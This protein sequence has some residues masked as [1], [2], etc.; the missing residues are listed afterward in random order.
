[1]GMSDWSFLSGVLGT[2]DVTRDPVSDPPA[3]PGGGSFVYGFD[4]KVDTIGAVALKVDA[5]NNPDH[6][7]SAKGASV[8]GAIMRGVS[9]EKTNFSPFLFAGLQGGPPSVND[10]GYLM[11]LEDG[12][13]YRIVVVKGKIIDGIPAATT[14][15]SLLRS[16]ATYSIPTGG[17]WHHIRMDMIVQGTGEVYIQCYEN[18]LDEND[19]D[20]PEWAAIPGC[21]QFIDDA[22]GV[23]SG[24]LPFT[25]G[26]MGYGFASKAISRRAYFDYLQMLRQV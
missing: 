23:N 19:V 11:G 8:R 16:T 25:A 17:R 21:E 7:P 14:E 3:P 20:A 22:L 24:S 12:D 15:N 18:D 10:Q 1:M 5:G 26:Y 4:S 2:G 9:S 6:A 13:P